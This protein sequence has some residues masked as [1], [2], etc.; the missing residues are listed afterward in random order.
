MKL[1]FNTV[2]SCPLTLK[3][4]KCGLH[5]QCQTCWQYTIVMSCFTQTRLSTDKL[6]DVELIDILNKSVISC[7]L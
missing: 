4:Y 7:T 2:M 6:L 1:V 5:Q 3:H